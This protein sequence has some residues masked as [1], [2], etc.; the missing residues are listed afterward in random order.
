MSMSQHL[1]VQLYSV[2][3]GPRVL[4]PV[5]KASLIFPAFPKML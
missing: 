2:S 3:F 1:T 4:V 5:P